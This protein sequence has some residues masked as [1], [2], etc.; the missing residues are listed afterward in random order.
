M[1]ECGDEEWIYKQIR[2]FNK[3]Y[4]KTGQAFPCFY[5]PESPTARVI[6]QRTGTM[7]MVH[8]VLWPCACLTAGA[9][10]WFGLCV[11]WWR[12][13]QKGTEYGQYRQV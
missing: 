5:D 3:Q 13:D 11:G 7:T 4:G 12:I 2:I 1:Y 10:L 9:V 8:A 6:V